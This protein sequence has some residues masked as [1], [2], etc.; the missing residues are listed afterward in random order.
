MLTTINVGFNK[1]DAF[2]I[3]DINLALFV[4]FIYICYCYALVICICA[5]THRPLWQL[6]NGWVLN[7]LS[8]HVSKI[9]NNNY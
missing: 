4:Q 6:L 9:I 5:H 7:T 2:I 3:N 1:V 8:F